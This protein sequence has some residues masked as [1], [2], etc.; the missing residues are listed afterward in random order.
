MVHPGFPERVTVQSHP[1]QS[2]ILNQ[3]P[4]HTWSTI[5][6]PIP[7]TARSLGFS[8]PPHC[9]RI[10]LDR[11]QVIDMKAL[12]DVPPHCGCNGPCF[13]PC[14]EHRMSSAMVW[15]GGEKIQDTRESF[16]LYI[17]EP[18]KMVS[19]LQ[20]QCSILNHERTI[21]HFF[22]FGE[23]QREWV[24]YVGSVSPILTDLCTGHHI[25]RTW[26]EVQCNAST[27]WKV[28]PECL[29]TNHLHSV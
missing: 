23:T 28:V 10:V 14:P 20:S 1:R 21:Y 7:N 24:R 6:I 15:E 16:S 9:D 5:N 18:K 12:W 2:L 13:G 26:T 19:A 27:M 17:V 8:H 4:L 3:T 22:L 29:H 25:P 11:M